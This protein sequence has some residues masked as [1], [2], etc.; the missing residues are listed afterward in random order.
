MVQGHEQLSGRVH[1]AGT[2]SSVAFESGDRFVVGNWAQSPIGPMFDVMWAD[3]DGRRTLLVPDERI[4]GF[5]TQIYDFD[6]LVV[7]PF[8]VV[9]D[10]RTTRVDSAR[11]NLQMQGGVKVPILPPRR[12]LAFT[13]WVE[14]PL[15][16]LL[17]GV[18][19]HGTSPT[20]AVEWYQATS[21]RWVSSAAATRNGTNLGPSRRITDPLRVGFSEPPARPSIVSVR[22]TIDLPGSR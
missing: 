17:L 6:D 10:D 13:R 3:P 15:A 9:G 1:V 2:I 16:R 22:V 5:I 8:E 11:L 14:A 12:P 4:G 19:A 20:G 21:L 7:E 18:N